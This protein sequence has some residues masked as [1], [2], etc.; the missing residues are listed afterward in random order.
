MTWAILGPS[1]FAYCSRPSN[2]HRQFF[3]FVAAMN[4]QRRIELRV[5]RQE[6]FATFASPIFARIP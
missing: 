2:L 5:L 6:D 4:R 3:Q 1:M